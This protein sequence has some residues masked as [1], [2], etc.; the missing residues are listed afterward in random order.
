MA[1]IVSFYLFKDIVSVLVFTLPIRSQENTSYYTEREE[2]S[3]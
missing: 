2:N 3:V 1:L